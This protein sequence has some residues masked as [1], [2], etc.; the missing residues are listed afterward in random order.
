[1]TQNITINIDAIDVPPEPNLVRAM[2][3]ILS[4]CAHKPKAISAILDDKKAKLIAAVAEE[5]LIKKS[6]FPDKFQY[7]GYLYIRM[8]GDSSWHRKYFVLS[9]NFLF[10]GD[11]KYSTILSLCLPLSGSHINRNP[12]DMIFDIK[13]YSFRA[14]SANICKE[15][16]QQIETASTL[17]IYDIYRFRYELGKI[18]ISLHLYICT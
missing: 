9:N 4:P 15:W 14:P 2:S 12:S 18:S 16:I 6:A 10:S 1:M 8:D 11:T 17:T 3:P 13:P 5:E 7:S